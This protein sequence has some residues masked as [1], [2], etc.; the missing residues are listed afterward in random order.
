MKQ[1]LSLNPWASL[2]HIL[3][4][5]PR[6]VR[7]EVPLLL[8]VVEQGTI[9]P[10]TAPTGTLARF[11]GHHPLRAQVL[12]LTS[13]LRGTRRS[14]LAAVDSPLP[15]SLDPPMGWGL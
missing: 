3:R 4:S 2:I 7:P 13:G 5:D 8:A 15:F 1:T 9:P 11:L 6:A 14:G 12:N 10:Q